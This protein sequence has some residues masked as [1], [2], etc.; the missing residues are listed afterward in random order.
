MM[1]RFWSIEEMNNKILTKEEKACKKHFEVNTRRLE[2]GCYEVKLPL[3][4]ST[5]R[6]DDSYDIAKVKIL[7]LQQR[8]LKQPQVKKDY[9]DFLEE[10]VQLGHMT[11]L[12]AAEEKRN[13][14]NFYMPHHGVLKETS[15]TTKLRV[16]FNG[17]EKSSNGVSLNH[18]GETVM[19][20]WKQELWRLKRPRR[21]YL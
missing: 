14:P 9:S 11:T 19:D 1:Q 12:D 4:D 2:T 3:S 17:S 21:S 16:V 5:D 18:P 6:L 13:S 10:Y 15:C 8:L 20:A 7:T